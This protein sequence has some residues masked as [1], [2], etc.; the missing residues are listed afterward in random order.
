MVDSGFVYSGFRDTVVCYVCG[1]D[2]GEWSH[3]ASPHVEHLRE[4]PLCAINVLWKRNMDT[5][6][7]T[8]ALS[9][10]A[11]TSPLFRGVYPAD[12]LPK[13]F[14]YPA[15]FVVN[16]DPSTKGGTHWIAVYMDENGRGD[17]FDSYGIT[18]FIREH[19]NFM[20]RVC[21]SWKWNKVKLQGWG[22]T[23]CG[24]YAAV[25]IFHRSKGHSMK[26]FLSSFDNSNSVNNDSKFMKIYDEIF[27]CCSIWEHNN[28]SCF[29]TC[30]GSRA[31]V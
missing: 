18:P 31:A 25:F 3:G 7:L 22:S 2:V 23:V 15:S 27:T 29:Q 9:S 21:A 24:N 10:N 14:N 28:S 11:H 6:Q 30:R 19:I 13:S 8:N 20:N 4:N 5:R 26:K 1:A 12:K 17:Y 16:T